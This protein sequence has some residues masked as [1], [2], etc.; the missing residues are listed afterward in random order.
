MST[1]IESF[2]ILHYSPFVI[3]PLFEAFYE[4]THVQPNDIL[5][6]YIVLP[7]TLPENSRLYLKRAT[8]A[9][10]LSTFCK[11]SSR[12]YGLPERVLELREV[13]HACIQLVIDSGGIGVNSDLSVQFRCRNI[14][15]STCPKD[16]IMAAEKL[17]KLCQSYDVPSIYRLLGV[18]KI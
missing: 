6:A 12:L 10:S 8:V 11:E 18:K 7:L 4:N 17:G 1:A 3:A 2:A 9:S 16:A 13:T 14:D 15:A 5:L